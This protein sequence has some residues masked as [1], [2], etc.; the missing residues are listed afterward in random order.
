[1]KGCRPARDPGLLVAP[2]RTLSR[3]LDQ[4]ARVVGRGR[5]FAAIVALVVASC[6]IPTD[7]APR[8]LAA[9][10]VPFG[11]LDS[12]TTVVPAGAPDEPSATAEV[13]LVASG[14]LAP[15]A[16]TVPSPVTLGQVIGALL[17]GP[18]DLE[19]RSGLQS[20]IDPGTRLLEASVLGRTAS[21]DL[22]E[23][24]LAT[25]TQAQILALAQLVFTATQ[26]EGVERVSLS[27][28]GQ[29]LED[30]PAAD[31]TLRRGPLTRDDYLAL[32]PEG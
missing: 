26:L 13:F 25:P 32:V 7:D 10:A 29:P 17:T 12:T 19:T 31:G 15:V 18:S 14:R 27:L 24:F 1:V 3:V 30:V 5:G 22:S 20:A 21:V 28:G 16:R 2:G 23:A 6:G 4:V 9:D 11:L 8:P